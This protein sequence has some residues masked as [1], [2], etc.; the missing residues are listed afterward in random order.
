MEVKVIV[1]FDILEEYREVRDELREYLKDIGGNFLQYSVYVADLDKRGV[2]ALIKG[3]RRI[4]KK[5]G[6]RVD[7]LFPCKKCYNNIKTIN[8]YHI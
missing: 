8:T 6:G 2:E 7:I 3:I 1:V 5:G 4:L